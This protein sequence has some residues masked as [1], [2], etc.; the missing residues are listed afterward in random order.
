MIPHNY[1]YDPRQFSVTPAGARVKPWE[2]WSGPLAAKYGLSRQESAIMRLAAWNVGA[3]AQHP[4]VANAQLRRAIRD[5]KTIDDINRVQFAE[6]QAALFAELAAERGAVFWDGRFVSEARKALEEQEA[7]EAQMAAE[8][9]REWRR[10]QDLEWAAAVR[11]ARFARVYARD[12][13]PPPALES[14]PN[15]RPPEFT[16]M[17][18]AEMRANASIRD[19]A[20]QCL[21]H[22]LDFLPRDS[23]RRV[24]EE[25]SRLDAW[26]ESVN[27]MANTGPNFEVFS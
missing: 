13:L 10:Q 15:Y 16:G 7:L 3:V 8:R 12:D 21:E 9:E 1:G 17:D 20:E 14:F 27:Y 25:F 26:W 18:M 19:G 23:A 24:Q 6:W 4:A 2:I 22:D 11:D 5:A